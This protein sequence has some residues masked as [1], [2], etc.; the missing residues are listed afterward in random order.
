MLK[1]IIDAFTM[2]ECRSDTPMT[3]LARIEYHKEYED[4]KQA[5]GRTPKECELKAIFFS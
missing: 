2:A 4:L 3:R 1:H 5:L